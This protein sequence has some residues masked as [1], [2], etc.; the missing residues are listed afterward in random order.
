MDERQLPMSD[1]IQQE[2]PEAEG[3]PPGIPA[4]AF[5][6]TPLFTANHAARYQRQLLIRELQSE[7]DRLL[8]CFVGGE[9]AE[10]DRNDTAGFV[11][12]L[13][14]VHADDHVDLM[15]HS[16]G[17]DVDAAEKLIRLVRSKVGEKGS[18]RVIVPEYAKSAATLMALGADSLLMSDSSELGAIDPQFDLHDGHGNEICH[19]VLVYLEAYEQHA[20]ALRDDPQDPVAQLMFD[21]FDPTLVKK[22]EVIKGRTRTLA[23]NLLKRRGKNFSA[24]TGTLMD[25]NR[26]QSHNQM[27]SAQ[28]AVDIG[29]DVEILS[30]DDPLWQKYWQLYCHLRLAIEPKQKIFESD[31]VSLPV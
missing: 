16:V 31:Y 2:G 18:I 11:D 14:N 9:R 6:K 5:S 27:I 22:F 17:G 28:D 13:H 12:L 30:A 10:I 23:E 15:L 1:E 21:K 24:I 8:L 29:L 25:I 4:R 26:W 3:A 7:V 19:S 20:K